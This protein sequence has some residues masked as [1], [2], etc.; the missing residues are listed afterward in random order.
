MSSHILKNI[1][2]IFSAIFLPLTLFANDG[3]FYAK[4]NQLIPISETKIK[5][6]KEILSLKKVNEEYIEVNV[7]YEFFNPEDDKKLLVGFEAFSPWGDVDG[8]PKNGKHPYMNDFT[9]NINDSSLS[10]KIAYVHD[11]SYYQNGKVK[12]EKLS[13]IT[14]NIQAENYVNFYYIYYFDALFK[15]G[16][17]VVKHSYKYKLSNSI[18]YHYDFGYILTAA[19]RWGNKQID[20]FTLIIDMGEFESFNVSN[21]FFKNQNDWS[22][23]GVGK[24][25]FMKK[26]TLP[27]D[28]DAVSFIIKQGNILF[29]RKNF[30]PQGELFIY[31]FSGYQL[32]LKDFSKLPFSYYM[33]DD[34][35]HPQSEFQ[36]KILKN[37]PF[38]RR[39]Y[40]FK[41]KELQEYFEKQNWYIPDA[42]YEAKVESLSEIEKEWIN[43]FLK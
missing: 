39:G 20:D 30:K 31:T 26:D 9:V 5:V 28:H 33:Q 27:I 38:A 2:S 6:Q 12:S 22:I 25:V 15:K 21:T 4:G 43:K 36:N 34:I 35:P 18:A 8:T 14:K 37:L 42:N 24:T 17:N 40:I 10:Y 7:Y 41:T 29:Q 11:S 3:A 1:F 23:Q 16:L 32:G 19:T 13:I